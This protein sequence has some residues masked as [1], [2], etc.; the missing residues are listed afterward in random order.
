MDYQKQSE[1]LFDL[2]KDVELFLN[3]YRQPFCTYAV[4]AHLETASVGSS[5]FSGWLSNRFMRRW[6]HAPRSENL[7]QVVTTLKA[8]AVD[9]RQDVY[10]RVAR[11]GDAIWLDI[12]DVAWKK[13]RITAK[14]WSIETSAAGPKFQRSNSSLALT[15]PSK[16]PDLAAL[17]QF[18]N[19][20]S[21]NDWI[22]VSSWLVGCLS[23]TGPYPVLVVQ[24]PQGGA[25]STLTRALR[26]LV[27]P[28]QAP[29]RELPHSNRDMLVS[30]MSSW[31]QAFDNIGGRLPDR[32]SDDFCR[33]AT[34]SG[35][36]AR[37]LYKDGAEFVMQAARPLLLNGLGDFVAQADLA[38][39]TIQIEVPSISRGKRL[40]EADYWSRW[41]IFKPDIMSG[42]IRSISTALAG[43]VRGVLPAELPRMADFAAWIY[44]ASPRLPWSYAEFEGAYADIKRQSA[45]QTAQDSPLPAALSKVLGAASTAVWEG[46][47]TA[48]LAALNGP[49][50][51]DHQTKR[52]ASWPADAGWLSRRLRAL[53]PI[54]PTA[55]NIR[56]DFIRK[57]DRLIRLERCPDPAKSLPAPVKGPPKRRLSKG[58]AGP[59]SPATS[60]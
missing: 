43:Q 42:L 34:G 24:G 54:L 57:A 36:G 51:S 15:V 52:H 21:N 47:P 8:M 60:A 13:I 3:Q 22:L 18:L 58:S 35:F 19:V 39:R 26:S 37:K 28:N 1:E 49:M 55:M 20:E 14:G 48:L 38:D 46:T 56:V 6:G 41:A 29:T 27:D 33:L 9:D 2:A 25:K 45:L 59:A 10:V 40:L 5:E 17:K 4:N 16:R 50:I 53:E 30:A 44:W 11:V 32:L 7:R 12:C 23:P 31:V